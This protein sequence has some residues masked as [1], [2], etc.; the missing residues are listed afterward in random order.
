MTY[1]TNDSDSSILRSTKTTTRRRPEKSNVLPFKRSARCGARKLRAPLGA[2]H[3]QKIISAQL[4][5]FPLC[6]RDNSIPVLGRNA[7]P[8][9]PLQSPPM[10]DTDISRKLGDGR[11]KIEQFSKGHGELI[12]RD[13]L[14]L[15]HG[16][17]FPTTKYRTPRT[18]SPMGRNPTP[19]QFNRGLARRLK[20]ARIAA[21]YEN[22]KEFAEL[23][24]VH[25]ER[26]KKWESGRTPIQHE[27]IP[28]ACELT[29]KDANYFFQIEAREQKLKQTG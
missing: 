4:F 6:G 9:F 28:R 20:S 8:L 13:E 16:L 27:F 19:I 3:R 1:H 23:L 7:A 10:T 24:G 15:Q 5:P 29:G 14:S 25:W 21:G 18:I 2:M 26:Y 22:L 17:I 11:P 12:A